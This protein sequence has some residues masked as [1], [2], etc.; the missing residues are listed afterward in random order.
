VDSKAA[1]L[2]EV[3]LDA[4]GKG[5]VRVPACAEPG[6]VRVTVVNGEI[7]GAATTYLD[8]VDQ[9]TYDAFAEAAA[10]ARP[11]A[12]P[13]H[14][15]FLGDSLTDF[16]RG[17]NYTDQVSFWLNQVHGGQVTYR[18]AGVGGDY[19]TRV[20]QRMDADPKV[21]RPDAY[22]DL[23]TPRPTRVFIM[24]GHNDSKLSST[25]GFVDTCVPIDEFRT[26]YARVLER[27]R[28]ET[29]GAPQL[30]LS[31]TSGVYEITKA[32]ADKAVAAGRG[33]SL[34]SKPEML[35]LFNAATRDVAAAAGAEYLDVHTPTRTHPDM[36]GLFVADG[37]HLSLA[38][39]HL[40]AL[41]ILKHLGR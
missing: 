38:G 2:L 5:A 20:Q 11:G 23:Y 8:T 3:T 30:V 32:N 27:I 26:V 40:I 4:A 39:N 33:A 14:F 28:Q 41:E 15:L 9:P 29:G 7:G 37:V 35:E 18:N 10:K 6:L 34:F 17:Q 13:A 36:A 25:S 19:I 12:L 24:L 22:K 16:L 1:T 21:Y 31:A